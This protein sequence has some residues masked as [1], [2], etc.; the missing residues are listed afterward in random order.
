MATFVVTTT[1][2]AE[3]CDAAM[4]EAPDPDALAKVSVV[5]GVTYCTCPFGVHGSVTIVKADDAR[6]VQRLGS[7]SKVERYATTQ[8]EAGPLA[9]APHH[10]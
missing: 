6:V 4:H 10:A 1:H 5:G 8:A 3:D 2:R 9:A 7:R